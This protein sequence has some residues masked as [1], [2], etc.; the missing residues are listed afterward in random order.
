MI[1]AIEES[2]ETG[3]NCTLT[4]LKNVRVLVLDGAHRV[5][6]FRAPEVRDKLP[7]VTARVYL[8]RD[9]KRFLVSDFHTVGSCLNDIDSVGVRTSAF[10]RVHT[11][12]SVYRDATQQSAAEVEANY[13]GREKTIVE[14]LRENGTAGTCTS[15]SSCVGSATPSVAF[16]AASTASWPWGCTGSPTLRRLCWGCWMASSVSIF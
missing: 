13:G 15:W 11:F 7:V 16:S 9:K 5:E 4:A 10:D 8:R 1:K 12:L 2:K 6:A 3:T 14:A